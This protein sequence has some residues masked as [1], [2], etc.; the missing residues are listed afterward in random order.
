MNLYHGSNQRVNSPKLIPSKR[1]LDFGEG[2]YLTSD[3]DQAK[4]WAV[5]TTKNREAGTATIS[6]F[7]IDESVFSS[8]ETL[9][10][11]YPDKNWLHYVCANRTGKTLNKDYDIVIGPVADDQV[12]RTVNDY[13]NGYFSEDIAL[14]ML[15]PQKLKDQY[16][17]KTEKALSYLKYR[18]GRIL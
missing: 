16:A 17:F 3:Y 8:L 12:I 1:Y 13:I 15:L 14:Q 9:I 4:K 11:T 7:E 6:V 2:F 18:T 10:F 5:R